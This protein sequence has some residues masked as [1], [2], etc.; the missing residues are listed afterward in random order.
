MEIG[1]TQQAEQ[2]CRSMYM[3]SKRVILTSVTL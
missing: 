2:A 3:A 1:N